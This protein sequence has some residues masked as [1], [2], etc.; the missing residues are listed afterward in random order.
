MIDFLSR[1]GWMTTRYAR[2]MAG[3]AA[4]LIALLGIT[5]GWL[6][7]TATPPAGTPSGPYS[8]PSTHIIQNRDD[9][10]SRAADQNHLFNQ[11][12]PSTNGSNNMSNPGTGATLVPSD[13][14][15]SQ[16]PTTATGAAPDVSGSAG[17]EKPGTPNQAL[18]RDQEAKF[19]QLMPSSANE[20]P[21][22]TLTRTQAISGAL[23][24]NYDIQ[25]KTYDE[26]AAQAL[27]RQAHGAFDPVFNAE[28]SYEDIRNPQN[29]QDFIA[30]GGTPE[31]IL[32][33]TPRIFRENNEHYK[34]ALD[35]KIPTGMQYEIKTQ[36][37][38]LSNT[39]NQTSPLSL[40]TPEYQ[41]FTGVTISQPFLRG[42]GTDVNNSEIRAAIV[43]KLA[44]RYQVQDQMLTTISQVLQSYY[45]LTYL[46]KELEAKREDRDLGIRLVRDRFQSLEK[47]Q[48]SSREV[49][50]S[51]SA[52]A[53]IIED[54]TKAQ[55]ELIDQQTILEALVS[56]SLNHAAEFVY[57]PVSPMAT[58]K[59]NMSVD[60]LVNQALIHRPKY[61]EARQ[62][63]EE[64]NIKLVYA[65]NQTYPQL[66]MKGTYGVNGLSSTF[67]NSYYRQV[68]P[69]G[70]QW[71]IG[72]S[73]SVP[74]GNNDAEGKVDE[75][76]AHKK[77]ALL[78]LKEIEMDTDLLVRKLAATFRSDEN[79]LRAME[80][81]SQTAG[82]NL[83][84]EQVRL[85]KGLSSDLD[86]L[87]YRRDA[88]EAEAR[89]LAAMADLNCA[90]VQ[91]MEATGLLFE[92]LNVHFA[93]N[94]AP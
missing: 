46:T 88:T 75:I 22:R 69:Q 10:E 87:K 76:E 92:K 60:E 34:L 68:I 6:P 57:Q 64:Q 38:I 71:S 77:Q 33:G 48:V 65:R 23:S 93:T 86:V 5:F 73:F 19:E 18:S 91:L 7:A 14:A 59:I 51:E 42:F 50:R 17:Q 45:Q 11:S 29:T 55:N 54:Y 53:E 72:L 61:L 83:S 3:S 36:L 16:T 21:T 89:R 39:L 1:S 26:E 94:T 2:L 84:E 52:L 35:G 9:R 56:S 63:V 66:D 37:D 90:Y 30:T 82:D 8:P 13:N 32:N 78:N 47:G 25:I 40:F 4:G 74:I 79:R 49:N 44:A 24:Q 80:L 67:Q 41:S 20:L 62:R 58:P 28:G 43:N 70:P 15:A 27:A 85:E 81:F 12:E 31:E